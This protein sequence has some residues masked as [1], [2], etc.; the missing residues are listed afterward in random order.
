VK[1]LRVLVKETLGASLVQQLG[2]DIA[3]ACATLSE[4]G[5]LH[6]HDRKRVKTNPGF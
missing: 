5:G 3:Q 2:A 4:K 6:P 1:V